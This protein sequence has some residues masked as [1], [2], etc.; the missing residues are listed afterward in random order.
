MKPYEIDKI[1][2]SIL[3]I[4]SS[5]AKASPEDISKQLNI[6]P[7]EVIKK[8][9]KLEKE[10][11]ILGY[12]THINWQR[13]KQ[14]EVQALIEVR[15]TPEKSVGFD[16]VA[17]QIYK[18]DEVSSVTLMSGGYDLLVIVEGKNLRD[19]ALFVAEKLATIKGVLSTVSHFILKKFK[20]DHVVLVDQGETKRLP[21]AP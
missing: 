5:N 15:V 19:V 6:T 2:E 14:H 20:E 17:E 11:I 12:K 7:E 8:I 16:H 13:V 4:L 9:E 3:E 21:I 10:K 18:F 1:E